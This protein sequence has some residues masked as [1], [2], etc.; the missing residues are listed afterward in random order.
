MIE[1]LG[2]VLAQVQEVLADAT[3]DLPVG[4]A[5]LV[6]DAQVRVDEWAQVVLACQR[7]LNATSAVQAVALAAVG[8]VDEVQGPDASWV[9]VD[10][11]PGFVGEFAAVTVAPMLGLT[12]RGAQDRLQTAAGLVSR[13]PG[14]LAAMGAGE[15][16]SWR[17][18]IIVAE[19][20][21]TDAAG[22]AAVEAII[23]PRVL[24][25]TGGRVR[26][27]TRRA[28]ARVDAEALRIRAA[29]ARLGRSVRV[30]PSPVVG[31]S[32]WAAVLPAHESALCKAAVDE[33]A[34]ALVR[35]DPD[36]CM[37]QARADALVDLILAR[38]QVSTTVNLS[39]PVQTLTVDAPP[40][41]TVLDEDGVVV[42]PSWQQ[43]CAM[44]YEIP[45]VGVI[46]GDVVAGIC[47]RFDTHIR[48]V[49]L[50]EATGTTVETGSAGYRPSAAVRRF[51]TTRDGHCRAP[52]CARAARFCD[53]DHVV[54][55]PIGK[56]EPPNLLTLCRRHHRMKHQ[57]R[58]R[59]VMTR[60]GVCT[61]TD[62][63]GQDFITHPV[64]HHDTL[65]A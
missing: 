5:Q 62:P 9:A 51:V 4:D 63:F 48:R 3:S 15:L 43:V 54:S 64:N 16:D 26:A 6:G 27:R 50:D 58:W 34:C 29:K 13:L 59:V 25:E 32:E 28:L 1:M 8:A 55:W 39:I 44:G 2:R 7:V 30:W 36:L 24:T 61:W 19:T 21:E 49:L 20:A 18:S 42:G 17:A 56:T 11:G 22:S 23:L 31:L 52:G 46:P 12:S 53:L 57:T 10:R 47:A 33:H 37:D 65:A 35:D 41:Q 40:D 60:D 14:T 45:G 38:V